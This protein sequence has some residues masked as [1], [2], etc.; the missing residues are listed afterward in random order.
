MLS[1]WGTAGA[2]ARVYT[3]GNTQD[4][5]AS[6]R[7]SQKT[8]EVFVLF[9]NRGHRNDC[10]D[11]V[12]TMVTPQRHKKNGLH[13][14]AKIDSD[15][16]SNLKGCPALLGFKPISRWRWSR[17]PLCVFFLQRGPCLYN[18]GRGSSQCWY[19]FTHQRYCRHM[20][21][22]TAAAWEASLT[23]HFLGP[24]SLTNKFGSRSA[25]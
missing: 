22:V 14:S 6:Q 15:G 5:Q 19:C 25:W 10:V 18:Y 2:A 4:S 9:G 21:L 23:F 8:D 13:L 24:G 3:V 20:K 12:V 7:N 11:R 16:E 17:V 1:C